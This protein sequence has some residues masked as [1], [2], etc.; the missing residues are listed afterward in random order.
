[1]R[2]PLQP[3]DWAIKPLSAEWTSGC[4]RLPVIPLAAF[5]HA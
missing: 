4:L 3:E 5:A 1:M 2:A